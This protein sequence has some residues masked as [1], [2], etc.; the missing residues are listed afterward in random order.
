MGSIFM[1]EKKAYTAEEKF[2]ILKV[3]SEG[4]YSINEI[5]SIYNVHKSSIVEWKENYDKYGTEGLKRS[6]TW[7]KYSYELKLSAIKDY[8]TSDYSLR[9]VTRRYNLTNKSTLIQWIN[10][11]NSHRE[12]KATTEGKSHSM[13]KSRSTTLEERI[14]V[15][16]YCIENGKGYQ[17]AADTYEVSYQQVYQWTKKYENGGEEALRDR[18]GRNKVEL[19]LSSE[20]KIKLEMKNLER[21]NE[22][23]RAENGFLKKLEELERRRY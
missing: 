2:E 18:R 8:L 6:S 14:Q 16:L 1:S 21:Q 10:K 19:E 7:K 4:K 15:V 9:E 23:L 20:E 13:T 5:C 3:C 11:Y 17:K 22:R 12:I